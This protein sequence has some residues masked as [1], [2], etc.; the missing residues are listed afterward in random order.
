MYQVSVYIV[1]VLPHVQYGAVGIVIYLYFT[2]K[3]GQTGYRLITPCSVCSSVV[4]YILADAT[5]VR[6]QHIH[7]Y[8]AYV[9]RHSPQGMQ[10]RYMYMRIFTVMCRKTN[11]HLQNEVYSQHH[12]GQVEM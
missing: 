10:R 3:T 11:K 7:T 5:S 12:Q 9:I 1:N 4:Q 6:C 2:N 8:Q